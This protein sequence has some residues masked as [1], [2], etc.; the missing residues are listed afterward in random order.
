MRMDAARSAGMWVTLLYVRVTLETAMRR[1]AR[2]ERVVPLDTLSDYFHWAE[3]AVE[4]V[5][6]HA[7]EVLIVEND[8]DAPRLDEGAASGGAGGL[9]GV[10]RS[11]D[12]SGSLAP[13]S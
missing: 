3:S 8:E 4:M 7:D 10:A 9:S 6:P 12:G 13:G 2:R 11:L 5:R 1:N